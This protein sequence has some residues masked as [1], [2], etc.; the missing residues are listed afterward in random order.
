MMNAGKLRLQDLAM[1][2][3]R[4]RERQAKQ[5]AMQEQLRAEAEAQGAKP[6]T[7]AG[8]GLSVGE[9]CREEEVCGASAA[10][11]ESKA[12]ATKAVNGVDP[13]LMEALGVNDMV[14]AEAQDRKMREMVFLE[15]VAAIE[16]GERN[17]EFQAEGDWLGEIEMTEEEKD[18]VMTV[19]VTMGA[20]QAASLREME[21][22][23]RFSQ[24]Q[25]PNQV[26]RGCCAAVSSPAPYTSDS[27]S[28]S[29]FC[30]LHT[31]CTTACQGIG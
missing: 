13:H 30:V 22:N 6:R 9:L 29:S 19:R 16:Y 17:R 31:G 14:V 21:R 18:A 4:K 10:L 27:T 20:K 11:V 26:R 23:A 1:A 2:I 8:V 7:A 3:D 25:G 12:R 15:D 28:F 5:L 24:A